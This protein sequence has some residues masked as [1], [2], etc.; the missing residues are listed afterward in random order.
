MGGRYEVDVMATYLLKME[1][2]IP[3]VF[4]L[5]FLSSTLMGDGPVLAENASKA[6][7]GEEDGARPVL[8]HYR[9]LFTKMGVIAEN[10]GP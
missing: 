9:H 6:A 3:Q 8:A 1:H 10:H 4:I 2:H 7:V 5:D